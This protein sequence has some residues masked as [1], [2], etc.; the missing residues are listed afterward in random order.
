M[1]KLHSELAHLL[2]ENQEITGILEQQTNVITE[3]D[4]DILKLKEANRYLEAQKYDKS[5]D[6][7]SRQFNTFTQTNSLKQ[8][9]PS[10]RLSQPKRC[11]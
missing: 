11:L 10:R 4:R 9:E 2:K 5:L 3:Q 1:D 6:E 8:L 7:D